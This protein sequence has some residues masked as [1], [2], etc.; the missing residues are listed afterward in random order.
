MK[1]KVDE[2]CNVIEVTITNNWEKALREASNT[3]AKTLKNVFCEGMTTQ[4][5]RV[6]HKVTEKPEE[7]KP[8]LAM[9][10]YGVFLAGPKHEDWEKSV[11]YL[12]VIAWAYV[13]DLLPA[14][15][16]EIS[17]INN[18]ALEQAK[19]GEE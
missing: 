1:I 5:N 2:Q 14:S 17:K 12:N 11:E 18:H 10:Q 8:V 4:R 3:I 7:G 9:K 15:F 13:E 16:G 6:W 19:G